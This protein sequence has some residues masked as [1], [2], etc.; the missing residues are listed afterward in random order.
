MTKSTPP[1]TLDASDLTYEQ[2][3]RILSWDAQQVEA[4]YQRG[5]IDEAKTCEK[6]KRHQI[7]AAVQEARDQAFD[8][9]EQHLYTASQINQALSEVF[10]RK[11]APKYFAAIIEDVGYA[12]AALQRKGEKKA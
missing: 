8:E 3:Q 5:R 11:T 4:A 6:A 10:N 1:K 2:V 7:E 12:L 9:A